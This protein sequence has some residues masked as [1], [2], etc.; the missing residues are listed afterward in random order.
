[1]VGHERDEM[2]GDGEPLKVFEARKFDLN[3]VAK[4]SWAVGVDKLLKSLS[5]FSSMP[6]SADFFLRAK[7]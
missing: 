2:V 1:M 4:A 7:Q 5:S 3:L 6:E